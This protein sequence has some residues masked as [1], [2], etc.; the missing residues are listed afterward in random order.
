MRGEEGVLSP[1]CGVQQELKSP[2]TSPSFLS[3]CEDSVHSA[4]D[5]L[6]KDSV[7][8]R[9]RPDPRLA[10]GAFS[11]SSSQTAC[12]GRTFAAAAE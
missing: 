9:R 8:G 12:H 4:M 5:S 1:S 6:L 10:F 3:A 2:E 7:L 11:G